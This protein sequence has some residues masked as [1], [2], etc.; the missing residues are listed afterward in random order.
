MFFDALGS[1]V[2]KENYL[3]QLNQFLAWNKLSNYDDLLKADERSIQRNLE[4][5]LIYLKDKYSPNYIPAIIAPVELFY[6]MNKINLNSKR[7][8]KLF[9]TKVKNG[10]YDSH[11]REHIGTL[12]DNTT[13]KRIKALI[14]FLASSGCHV[15]SIH[16]FA[17]KKQ[18]VI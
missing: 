7:L 18:N 13:K 11:T 6:T 12:L 14:L 1:D 15:G 17:R 9:S 16:D 4:D 5:Y 3:Y 2:T 10:G 8:H